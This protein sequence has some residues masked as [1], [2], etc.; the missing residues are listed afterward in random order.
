[1]LESG[2][3]GQPWSYLKEGARVRVVQG[4]LQGLT[5][6]VVREKGG[7]KLI[8]SVTFLKRSVAAEID[9]R[10]VRP[11]TEPFRTAPEEVLLPRHAAV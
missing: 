2:V 5:G 10:C 6:I 4:P 7:D 8:V 9:R 11:I 3:R 1:M